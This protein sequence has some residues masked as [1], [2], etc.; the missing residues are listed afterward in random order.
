M[1]T[2]SGSRSRLRIEFDA[3]EALMVR[4]RVLTVPHDRIV[5]VEVLPGW[6]SEILGVRFGVAISGFLK[7][8]VFT[9]PRGTRRLVSMRRG[10]PVL[11]V[12]LRGRKAGDD[13]DEILVSTPEAAAI[14]A[15]LGPSG[16]G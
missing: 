3:W 16:V 1:T 10:T 11:R 13:F 9:H 12:G 5:A 8:G 7:V 6:T 15:A 4:R 2:V 14:A